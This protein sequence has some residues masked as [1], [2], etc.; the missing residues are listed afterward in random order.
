MRRLALLI[1]LLLAA[2]LCAQEAPDPVQEKVRG[3]I[4][5]LSDDQ[6]QVRERSQRE[7]VGIGEPARKQLKES[8]DHADLE[9]RNRASLALIA[10][11]ESFGHAVE[12]AVAEGEG[13]RNHGRAALANLFRIDDAQS[14]RP[15]APFEMQMR[16]YGGGEELRM[17][18]P[19]ALAM[20]RLESVSGLRLFVSPGAHPLWQRVLAQPSMDLNV[21]G[22]V[23]QPAYVKPA[24]ENSLRALLGADASGVS[25]RV[26]PMRIGRATFLYLSASSEPLG[27]DQ[28]RRAGVELVNALLENDASSARAAALLAE[29]A[30]TDSSAADRIRREYLSS[31][32]ALRLLWLALALGP[33]DAVIAAVRKLDPAPALALLESADWTAM[34]LAARF[35]ECLEPPARARLLSPLITGSRKTLGLTAALWCA[36][37]SDLTPEARAR[38]QALLTLR[39]DGLA[40][41]AVRWFAGAPELSDA[42][43]EQ[44]W[45]AA[46]NQPAESAFFAATL[47]L[48][49]RPDIAQRLV[50]SARKALAGVQETQQA[51]AAAVLTGRTRPEDLALALDKLAR[52]NP[53]LTQRL[54]A[55]FT[56]CTELDAAAQDKLVAGLTHDDAAI[57][58]E[59]A[60]ALRVCA[61]GLRRDVVQRWAARI[62][63]AMGE[64]ETRAPRKILHSR[65]ALWAFQAALDDARALENLMAGVTGDD[66]EKAKLAGA[67]LP[68]ALAEAVLLKELESLRTRAKAP[69]AMMVSAE[70]YVEFC[71]RAV[72]AGDRAV[73]R[74][75]Y[76]LAITLNFPNN[77]M[78]RSEL[79]QLQQRLNRLPDNSA[80]QDLLPRGP[81]LNK[82]ELEP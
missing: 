13:R 16:Y 25:I 43:L 23:R 47:E 15:L 2:P 33:D 5:R 36:R 72:A 57:R 81:V 40:A 27:E 35:L 79:N 62:T 29:G 71:R 78:I 61:P 20:A 11:G 22:D 76:G 55:M 30:A 50:E 12:C 64:D 17:T 52:R 6:W 82:L 39:E 28:G 3:L 9:I 73:F 4:A 18:Q 51:L 34:S 8:L 21:G 58:R 68:D 75:Y 19:P 41:A 1:L 67:A 44:V 65:V 59:Y 14:L 31:P 38:A 66:P 69:H 7:L 77:Y 46:E 80:R 63:E 54:A 42:E 74:K 10:I 37:G 49:T 48:I 56:G 60:G 24:L 53:G 26:T 70:V 45:R 32:D